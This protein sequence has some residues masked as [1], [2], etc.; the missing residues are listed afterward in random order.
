MAPKKAQ[1]KK[2]RARDEDEDEEQDE[3]GEE[4]ED[5][6]EPPKK[7]TKQSGGAG[8]HLEGK[9]WKWVVSTRKPK[10]PLYLTVHKYKEKTYVSIR[11]YYVDDANNHKPGKK[12]ITLDVD[13][14]KK[15]QEWGKLDEAID[16][17]SG[18]E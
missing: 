4:Q 16:G 18:A 11:E 7:K 3:H 6:D 13:D 15:I 8:G 12:G 14:F 1:R 17:V 2:G 9:E 5:T 10:A